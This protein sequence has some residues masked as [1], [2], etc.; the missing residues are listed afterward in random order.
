MISEKIIYEN[1]K[2]YKYEHFKSILNVDFYDNNDKFY[3][4]KAHYYIIDCP[5]LDAFGHWIYESFI[6][7]ELLIELNKNIDNIK[8]LTSNTRKYVKSFLNFFNI[9]NEVVYTIEN[10]NNICYFPKIYSLNDTNTNIKEDIYYNHHLNYYINY[11]KNNIIDFKHHNKVV[12]LP[13]NNIDNYEPNDRKINNID[14]IKDLVINNGGCVIDTY[15][16]NNIFY[17][18][19]IL[20]NS[21]N[22]ILDYGSSF[23]VNTMFLNNKKIYMF[24]DNKC[25]MSQIFLSKLYAFILNKLLTNNNIIIISTNDLNS[26][27]NIFN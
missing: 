23:Y 7:I 3:N 2:S 8:I 14:N 22:I 11:I 9:K 20:Y 17:Q 13:R 25:L 12:L 24:D 19:S 21:D 10:Y 5:G 15:N 26:I 6:F 27:Q 4:E 1:L 18:F 16:L